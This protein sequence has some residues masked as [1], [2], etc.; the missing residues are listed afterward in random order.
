MAYTTKIRLKKRR[1][2]IKNKIYSTNSGRKQSLSHAKNKFARFNLSRYKRIFYFAGGVL[3]IFLFIGIIYGFSYI[4]TLQERLPTIDKPFGQKANATELYDKNGA[5][6]YRVY[7]DEDRDSVKLDEVPFL[8]KWAL[9]SAED[10]DF[11]KHGGVDILGIIRCGFRNI[12]GTGVSCGAS[13]I[14]Q[15]LLKLTSL[16][17]FNKYERKIAEAIM[18]VQMEKQYSKDQILEMYLTVV[19]EGS[20][21]YGVTRGAKVYFGKELRDLNL[22]EVA[23]LAAIPNSPNQYSPRNADG[24]ENV[25]PR[26]LY[27][28]DAMEKNIDNINNNY[29]ETTGKSED[30]LTKEMIN[31]ARNFELVYQKFSDKD[32]LKAPHFVFYVEKLLQQRGY[33]NGVP[34][35]MEELE[36]SGLKIY[37]TLDMDYQAIAEE[38][39]TLGATKYGKTYGADNA[40]IVALDPTNGEILAMVGSKDYWAEEIPKGCVAQ[41]CRFSGKVNILD[42]LQSYGSTMKPMIYYMSYM[43]GLVSPGSVIPDVPIKIGN[44]QPK[45]Y[46][47]GFYGMRTAR[48]MLSYSRNIPAIYLTNQMGVDNVVAEL[49]K[50]GYTTFDNPNGYGPSISVGGGDVKLIEHAQGYAVLANNGYYIQHEVIK[51]IV[52]RDGNVIYEHKPDPIQVADQRGTFMVSD[53]LNARKGGPGSTGM[54][55]DVAGKTGTSENAK[56]T[57]FATYTPEIVVVGWLGNNNNDPLNSANGNISAKPWISGFY[58]RIEPRLKGS[59]FAKPAGVI[60]SGSCSAEEGLS[61][62]GFGS[63]YSIAGI[64]VPSYVSVKAATV[65]TDQTNKL[66]RPIDIALGKSTTITIK[67]YKMPDPS[68]QSFADAYVAANGD[69]LG[70]LMPTTYCDINRNPSGTDIPWV[71]ITSPTSGTYVDTNSFNFSA[72]GYSGSGTISSMVLSEGST[73]IK[74]YTDSANESI[75]ITSGAHTYTVKVTDSNGKTGTATFTI[76]R[77]VAPTPTVTMI[78]TPTVSPTPI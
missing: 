21:I 74:S 13:T 64:N 23:I 77:G 29:K 17:G 69:K 50:W 18:A 40:A 43:R 71:E 54:N 41:S 75:D 26:Q 8:L 33:N 25:K 16:Y 6:L 24:Q 3:L 19:P 34:F 14:D 39:V 36:T 2:S 58:K 35:T 55:R 63:D 31:D 65:C 73:V 1:T 22:A 59:P 67:S 15:Q 27:V 30:I 60:S 61:C 57:L 44:Y 49:K 66:A 56:E 5:L 76:T 42:T 9:L 53:V 7:G 51:K 4:Q 20:N 70:A 45:N 68:L 48:D 78:A 28:L 47:G 12:T 72:K 11:Y 52:D 46:E 38:Q 37:T 62:N 32:K 10:K